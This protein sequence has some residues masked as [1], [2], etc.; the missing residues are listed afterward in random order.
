MTSIMNRA[1]YE[2]LR[3]GRP[4]PFLKA[5]I[6]IHA[7]SAAILRG[8]FGLSARA[9]ANDAGE[10]WSVIFPRGT[11]HGAN[12]NPI[13]GSITLTDDV[14]SEM[15]ANW[16]AEGSPALPVYFHHPPPIDEV[17]P[18]KRKEVFA[19]AGHME[20]FRITERGLEAR[21]AW[22]AE[23]QQKLDE[24]AYRFVSPEWQPSHIGRRDG[25]RR[26]WL[27]TAAA[28]TDTPFFNE[29]P[30]VAAAAPT[31]QHRSDNMDKKRICAALKLP[32]TCT[33][34]EMM[35][36]IEAKCHAS[37]GA[38]EAAEKLTAS[39]KLTGDL[40]AK[41]TAANAELVT[42]KAAADAAKAER[43]NEQVA[44]AIKEAKLEGRAV[45]AL[46]A[47]KT[48]KAATDIESVRELLATVA[49][50]VPLQA[51]GTPGTGAQLTAAN[52]K[53]QFDALVA[54]EQAKGTKYAEAVRVVTLANP[55]VS[56]MLFGK[57]AS[58]S[59]T[60]ST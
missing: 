49:K 46:V 16:K 37:A 31:P 5:A 29:M 36:A 42:L 12:L 30:R 23:G 53:A 50:D 41:L 38:D 24:D 18:E 28:L 8:S 58:T 39:V 15:I 44:A 45:D 57:P 26:G 52:A 33:D 60:S 32:E 3:Q 21:T 35:A 6:T 10:K 43:F 11:W 13:G 27:V 17:P 56:G 2:A 20:D 25:K 55:E 19:A 54:T 7:P 51:K 59:T 14:F 47:T 9:P 22:S 1:E 4:S 40:E 34:E 48:F